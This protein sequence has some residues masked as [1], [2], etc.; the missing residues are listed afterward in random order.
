MRTV[1][2]VFLVLAMAGT[3][4]AQNRGPSGEH[5]VK[6][7]PTQ[8]YVPPAVTKQGGDTVF[9]ATVIPSMPFN[10]SGNTFGYTNDYDEVCPYSG[11]TSP[12]VVYS[13]TPEYSLS[14]IVD[15]CGSNYD[16]KIYIYDSNLNLVDCNDDFYFEDFCGIY[17]SKIEFA[18]VIGGETYYIVID[19]YGG[20]YGD[21]IL[22]VYDSWHCFLECH[23]D[24]VDEGEPELVDGYV[25]MFNGGCNSSEFGAPFLE[26]NWTNDEDGVP[27][28][29]GT[30]WL[31]GTSGWF[32]GQS[33]EE[34][35]DTDWF[36]V[37]ALQ[38]GMM[39]FSV[40]SEFDCFMY[41]MSPTSCP[42]SIVEIETYASCFWTE[43]M[44]FPVTAGEE[45]WLRV[46]PAYDFGYLDEF[47]YVMTV[48]N[49]AFDV[50]PTEKM[51]WGGVK[52]L[53]R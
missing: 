24:A 27:P 47:I 44:T 25:D 32:L 26:I 45:V 34:T 1:I 9:D 20:D 15:L 46:E 38:T 35:R 17:V 39:E 43:T 16:T 41:K 29:D 3:A 40:R 2:V 22:N 14:L 19:G 30:A 4:L 7:S 53:Y 33:G 52:A 6:D 28:Y 50:V 36:R 37:Y 42:E 10:D 5:P 12:D 8:S 13:F 11:S 21:Y 51:S 31:C 49:N 23:P 18:E 48:S